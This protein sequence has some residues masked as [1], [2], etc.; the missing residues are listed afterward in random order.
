MAVVQDQIACDA[1]LYSEFG[2]GSSTSYACP[3]KSKITDTYGLTVSGNYETNQLVKQSDISQP[4][5]LLDIPI[6]VRLNWHLI[7]YNSCLIDYNHA[8]RF[9][10]YFNMFN[11]YWSNSSYVTISDGTNDTDYDILIDTRYN[12]AEANIFHNFDSRDKTLEYCMTNLCPGYTQLLLPS[13]KRVKAIYISDLLFHVYEANHTRIGGTNSDVSTRFCYRL[14]LEYKT[15]SIWY[16]VSPLYWRNQYDQ[17]ITSNMVGYT[18]RNRLYTDYT[19]GNSVNLN[20]NNLQGLA[21]VV[22]FFESGSSGG[23][24]NSSW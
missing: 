13:N 5:N 23:D 2:K 3:P 4:A 7:P 15:N 11:T 9:P 19:F 10:Q 8:K 14:S 20:S 17:T 6:Y 18:E 1:W 24:D 16:K 12:Y 21:I 22:D